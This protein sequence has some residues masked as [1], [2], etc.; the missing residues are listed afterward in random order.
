MQRIRNHKG[1]DCDV[2]WFYAKTPCNFKLFYNRPYFLMKTA[3]DIKACFFVTFCT[4]ND[5]LASKIQNLKQKRLLFFH[6]L[7]RK[8]GFLGWKTILMCARL[9]LHVRTINFMY[10]VH[11]CYIRQN[12]LK[13]IEMNKD[14]Q[15]KFDSSESKLDFHFI[16]KGLFQPK[17]IA[18]AVSC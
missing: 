9:I 4:Q 6:P 12:F 8:G 17:C 11:G 7:F 10:L 3:M 16:L 14:V 1:F 5:I 2:I 18:P 13:T 15:R